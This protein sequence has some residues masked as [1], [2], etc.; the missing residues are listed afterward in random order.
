MR[1]LRHHLFEL[2][3]IN[4]PIS[5]LVDALNHE[6]DR[7]IV[8][9]LAQCAK[10]GLELLCGDVSIAVLV[11]YVESLLEL[12]VLYRVCVIRTRDKTTLLSP[13]GLH[14]SKLLL[15]E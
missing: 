3:E 5:V 7:L 8:D 14:R 12:V 13:Q 15:W 6:R 9:F 10:D 1:A 4:V 2:G 11:K